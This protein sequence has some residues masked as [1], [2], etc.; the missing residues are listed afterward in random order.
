MSVEKRNLPASVHQRL[1]NQAHESGRTL[2]ELLQYFAIERLLYPLSISEYSGLFTLKGA[3]M[4][5]AWD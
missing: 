1:L 3:L 4:F 2:N 5:N